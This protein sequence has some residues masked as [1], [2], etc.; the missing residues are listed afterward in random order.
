MNK[1]KWRLL[2]DGIR[3]PF[4]HFAVEEA[5]LRGIDTGET[6]PTLRLRQVEPSVFI[7]VYQYPEEDVDVAYC[8]TQGIRIVRR[9]NPG[10]A[11]YQDA[12]SFCYSL[13]CP[14]AFLFNRFNIREAEQLYP[15]I[16]TAIIETCGDFGVNAEL[17][18]VNDVTIGGRKVYGSAQIEFYS[19]FVHSGTFLVNA[20]R[21]EMEKCLKPSMLKFS[22]KGFQNV[23]NRVINLGEAAGKDIAIQAVMDRLVVHLGE[24]LGVAFE[25]SGLTVA[26]TL[27]ADALYR[28]KYA[29]P[30]WT[31]RKKE[32]HA[33]VVSTKAR[34]GVITL[35]VSLDGDRLVGVHMKGDFLVP[36]QGELDRVT[37]AL[38]GKCIGAA[39]AIVN[40]SAL[41]ADIN[42]SLI[43]LL[44]S[45]ETSNRKENRK[46]DR[47]DR[48]RT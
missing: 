24:C 5:L 47:N 12:G 40:A 1:H 19:A 18:P 34:S 37:H 9:P 43:E 26:E 32:A 16:G 29:D 7:G 21:E 3:D 8:H 42:E 4:R 48:K 35:E 28:E 46:G 39:S 25:A 17:S 23:K 22:D 27:A 38:K 31:F 11:V 20:D 10:G 15:L 30:A 44:T 13:F 45:I 14:K 6:V 41:P 36:D 2:T 33:V